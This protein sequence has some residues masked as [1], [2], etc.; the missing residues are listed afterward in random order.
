MQHFQALYQQAKIRAIED[1]DDK[2]DLD[3]DEEELIETITNIPSI[4]KRTAHFTEEESE[5]W[6]HE[7][8]NQGVN[9]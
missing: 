8:K 4:A 3:T 9:F 2:S 1:S 5:Q 6:V 7:M